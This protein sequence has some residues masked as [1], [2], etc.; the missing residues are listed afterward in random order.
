LTR[1]EIFREKPRRAGFDGS[2]DD[3]RV[4]ETDFRSDVF[5]SRKYA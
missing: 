2:R 3:E 5:V 4:P 1:V